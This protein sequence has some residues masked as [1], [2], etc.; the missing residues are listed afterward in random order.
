MTITRR[1]LFGLAL[2]PLAPISANGQS[3]PK[4]FYDLLRERGF[5]ERAIQMLEAFQPSKKSWY[6]FEP[7]PDEK[8]ATYFRQLELNLKWG[9][10]FPVKPN[11]DNI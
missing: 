6:S 2:V 7:M 1:S 4:D 8:S 11:K 9:K 5:N 10:W 3:K